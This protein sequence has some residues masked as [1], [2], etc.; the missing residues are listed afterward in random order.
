MYVLFLFFKTIRTEYYVLFRV[1]IYIWRFSEIIFQELLFI[2]T[3]SFVHE[4]FFPQ[5]SILK[6]V[7]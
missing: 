4:D 7:C 1:F 3:I 5:W 6:N 2:I